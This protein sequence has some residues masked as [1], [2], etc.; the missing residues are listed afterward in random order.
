MYAIR[1]YYA[2]L[3][4]DP[5]AVSQIKDAMIRIASEAELRETLVIKGQKQ[6]QKF[7][8]DKTAELLWGS[9]Q[10]CMNS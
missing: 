6:Q 4:A 7:T 2:V 5:F 3:Y 8:W 9:V 1:S 10:I